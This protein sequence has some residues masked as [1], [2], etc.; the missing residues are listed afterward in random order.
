MADGHDE[1]RRDPSFIDEI[2]ARLVDA[3][4]RGAPLELVFAVRGRV[5]PVPGRHGERWR[6]RTTR[7]NVVTFRPEFVI[8]FAGASEPT[9]K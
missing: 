4:R 8:A 7:G 1:A 3:A 5:E 6:V 2:N 9:T